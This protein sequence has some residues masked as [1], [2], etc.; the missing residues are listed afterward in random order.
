MKRTIRG[1]E[2][3]TET[4]ALLGKISTGFYGDPTGYEERLYQTPEGYYFLYGIGGENS[5][6]PSEKLTCLSKARA[7]AWLESHPS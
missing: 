2:Y 4:A 7:A 1:Q 6:Y 5:P 3:D